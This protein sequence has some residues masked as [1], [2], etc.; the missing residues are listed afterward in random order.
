MSL[1]IKTGLLGGVVG[2]ETEGE[3]KERE[4]REMWVLGTLQSVELLSASL[5][6]SSVKDTLRRVNSKYHTWEF[7]SAAVCMSH[8]VGCTIMALYHTQIHKVQTLWT[9]V[10]LHSHRLLLHYTIWPKVSG[11]PRYLKKRC[12]QDV[13]HIKYT[14]RQTEDK[15]PPY[16]FSQL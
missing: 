10:S 4:E 6:A 7:G 14:W 8:K 11:Q 15:I 3:R 2:W 5:R 9:K 13:K 16:S 12:T 1:R